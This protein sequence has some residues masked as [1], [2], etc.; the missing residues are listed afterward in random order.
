[1]YRHLPRDVVLVVVDVEPQGPADEVLDEL[2]QRR[3]AVQRA[4]GAAE[5]VVA[6]GEEGGLVGGRV[7][8]NVEDVPDVGG[9]GER[10]VLEGE[11][12][13]GRV[14]G[15]GDVEF[16][17]PLALEVVM[18][19]QSLEVLFGRLCCWS[20]AYLGV[21]QSEVHTS[22]CTVPYLLCKQARIRVILSNEW[23]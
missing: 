6:V 13:G 14:R 20:R 5:D 17:R 4:L 11:A 15:D 19:G 23:C 3:L 8:G 18:E 22:A 9:D 16:L 21:P 7:G 12:E 2:T 1:V 10:R